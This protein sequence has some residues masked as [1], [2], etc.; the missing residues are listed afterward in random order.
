MRKI[1]LLK[2][3]V[4]VLL[5]ISLPL[6][7]S[8]YSTDIFVETEAG[9]IRRNPQLLIDLKGEVNY[10]GVYSVTSGE[11][12]YELITL[13]GGLTLMA[14]TENIN[15]TKILTENQMI[16]I[17]KK[18]ISISNSSLININTA[19]VTTLCIL[20]GIGNSKANAIINYRNNNGLFQSIEDITNV[21]GIS[22]EIF[23]KLKDY[24]CV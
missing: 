7:V 23:K 12:L 1:N 22:N 5:L 2:P 24:I 13:A 18:S 11:T 20:P 21:S 4:I 16:T 17:P 14:S 15:L 6:S 19:D 10:P 3:L 8:C 9:E